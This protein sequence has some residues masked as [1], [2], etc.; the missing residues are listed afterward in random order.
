MSHPLISKNSIKIINIF[1]IF[2]FE[3]IVIINQNHDIFLSK[4]SSLMNPTSWPYLLHSKKLL[5]IMLQN[6]NIKGILFFLWDQ[7]AWANLRIIQRLYYRVR[8]SRKMA[9]LLYILDEVSLSNSWTLHW[10]GEENFK[11]SIDLLSPLFQ[12]YRWGSQRNQHCTLDVLNTNK[13]SLVTHS[14]GMF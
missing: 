5:T 6:F 12:V 13:G 10:A 8:G 11:W 3:P 2:T 1:E 7:D 14:M 9:P 4:K